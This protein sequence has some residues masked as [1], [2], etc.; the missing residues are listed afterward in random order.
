ME[1]EE[2][3]SKPSSSSDRQ[4]TV[5]LSS[6]A[7]AATNKKVVVH[8]LFNSRQHFTSFGKV[9]PKLFCFRRTRFHFKL[10]IAEGE[11][12]CWKTP[13]HGWLFGLIGQVLTSYQKFIKSA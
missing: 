13:I 6:T 10:L 11:L 1:R 2:K 3:D 12:I 7:A 9:A 4:L 5:Q 8:L